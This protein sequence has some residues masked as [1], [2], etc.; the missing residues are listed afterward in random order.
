M[1]LLIAMVLPVLQRAKQIAN[2]AVSKANLRG[3][4]HALRLYAEDS[5]GRLPAARP[6]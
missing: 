2:D 6:K 3:T 5:D 4:F 1:S